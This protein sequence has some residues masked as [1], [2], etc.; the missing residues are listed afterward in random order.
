MNLDRR[1]LQLAR[2][3]RLALALTIGLG[4]A[5]GVFTVVQ[6]GFFSRIVGQVYLAGKSLPDV[7]AWLAALL[8]VILLRYLLSWGS[9]LAGNAI[10]VRV[11]SDLRLAVFQ[12]LLDLGP[13]YA[14]GERTGELSSVALEGIDALDAY[15]SQY[16][17]GLALAALVPLT[18]LLVVIPLDPLSGLVLLLTAPLIPLFMILIGNVAQALTRRQWQTLSRLSAYFLDVLQGLT[19]LKALGRSRAQTKVIAEA[20]DQYRQRTMNVLRVTFLSALVLEMVATLSTAVVAVEVGLRLLYGRLPF[21]QSLFVL[22]L[23]PEFYLPLRLLGTRFHAGMSGVAAAQR[24]FAILETPAQQTCTTPVPEEKLVP[25]EAELPFPPVIEFEDVS[26]SYAGQAGA[27]AS[28]KGITFRLFPGQKTALVGPSGAGKSTVAALL[29]GFIR[30][31][32]G[33]IMVNGR[34]LEQIDPYTW[35]SWVSWVPQKPYLFNDTV[36]AN[37]CLGR[38][39]ATLEQVE[40]AARQAEAHDFI[41]GFPQGYATQI[42]ERGVRLSAGQAQRIALARAFLVDA[43][44][45]VLDEAT[46]NLD[47]H[48]E[49]LVQ[50][51]LARLLQ[52]RTALIIAHRLTTTRSADQIL[53]LD[54]GQI[55]ERGKH[56]ELIHNNG[57]YRRLV[58]AYIDEPI[59]VDGAGSVRPAAVFRAPGQAALQ[60]GF[61]TLLPAS[62]GSA[63]QAPLSTSV[64]PGESISLRLLRRLFGFLAPFKGLVA[65]SALAGAATVLCGVGLMATSAYIISAAALRPSIA[66]LQVAIVGVRFFGISRGLFRYLERYLTHQVTFR[67]LASLRV[68]FYQALEPLAP[69]RLMMFRSGDLLA[70]IL[71]DIESLESFYV[72]VAA[73]P[74]AAVLV[75]LMVFA[76][77]AGFA[78]QLALV[79]LLTWLL[80]ALGVPSL[81]GWMSRRPG[82][83]LANWR[84]ELQATLVDGIQ[85]MADLI[86]F[87]RAR[88]R[89][90]QVGR[91]GHA[92]AAQQQRMAAISSLQNALVGLLANLS[93]WAVIV[94]AIPLVSGGRLP[95]VYL[96]VLAL[97]ALTSFEA[98]NPLPLA[99]QYLESNSQAAGRLFNLVDAPPAVSDPAAPLPP[100]PDAALEIRDLSFSYAGQ[101]PALLT[102]DHV[103]LTLPVGMRKAIVGP[104]GA[105]KTTLANLLLRFWEF[106]Q[107]QILLGGQDIRSYAQEDVRRCIGVVSQ[108][109]YLFSATVRDNLR[110]ARPQASQAEIVQAAR[111]AQIHDFIETLPQ[112]YDTW[113]GEQGLRLSGGER[114]RLAIARALLQDAPL[115]VLDEATAN[116]DA[117]TERE[118]LRSIFDLVEG[119]SLLVITHRL[120]GLEAMDEILVMDQ[121]RVVER[122]RQA[123]LLQA[124]GLYR[125]MWDL[126]N[127]VL[128]EWKGEND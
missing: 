109:T 21:E 99:A 98:V 67:L 9:D 1:L 31:D 68:W 53:V 66:E 83:W 74:F 123:D 47:P 79:W 44:L 2:K 5:A 65:L 62:Q 22:L 114:Q 81:A 96:A 110:I 46:V 27:R 87:G 4:F 72:R 15:F 80:A 108:N 69:A 51:S 41:L 115:L 105:G 94:L 42:G 125:R 120:V 111:R 84:V 59:P 23:A 102:L 122:G 54:Q 45:V 57:L 60:A 20:S 90:A 95:G 25:E 88:E 18:F 61:E 56:A 50:A 63:V 85:G 24:I 13:F 113:V 82:R 117:L 19:T 104:S 58:Q 35:H 36:M 32:T 107:G 112:G 16:L 48:S 64:V 97:V 3:S 55:A 7:A 118:I 126:Q 106:E 10:A 17:P 28:L 34:P 128:Q 100:P 91:L 29:L 37:I 86:A 43:P 49:A 78:R 124:G 11:K 127:Q 8:G 30:P 89:S 52:G 71:G 38:P 40:R 12:H 76:W 73:P 116:L 101:Q 70:R 39:D 119:R 14:R 6:A 103:F 75:A 77:L 121:G 93:L 92:L 33:R 26:F